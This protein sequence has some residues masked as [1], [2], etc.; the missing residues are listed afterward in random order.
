MTGS[1][2][3]PNVPLLKIQNGNLVMFD[4]DQTETTK[5]N[6]NT[7]WKFKIDPENKPSQKEIHLPTMIFQGLG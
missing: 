6:W 5:I 1:N 7:P 2:E 3:D 4:A